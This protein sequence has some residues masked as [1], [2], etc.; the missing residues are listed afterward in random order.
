MKFHALAIFLILCVPGI[1][2]GLAVDFKHDVVAGGE[3]LTIGDVA[4][5]RPAAEAGD[6]PGRELFP[7]PGPGETRCFKSRTLKAYILAAVSSESPIS[8]GGADVICVR[9]QG[10]RIGPERIESVVNERL[11]SALSHTGA[12]KVA[13]KLRSRPEPLS[14]PEGK[15]RWEVLFSDPD[16]LES[17]QA[18]VIIR[19]DGRPAANLTLTGQVEAFLPVV[20][21]ARRLS[22]GT[23]LGRAD[24]QMREENI[25]ELRNP[26]LQVEEAAG[27][28][29]KRSVA[30]NQVISG[31]DL[32]RPVLVE[33]RQLVTMILAK[34]ALRIRARGRATADGRKGEVIMVENMRSR[35]EVPCEVVGQ[36]VTRVDF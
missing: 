34:G 20:A 24:L 7:A 10:M 21:A 5:I 13:F 31:N 1:A 36:G 17:R 6:M 29:L 35:R 11:S 27:K 33:R 28:R 4:E 12:R 9:H 32:D 26:C 19:V 3:M 25:A 2:F 18:T 30:M 22:R 15:V 16:I 8:W 14:L 23:V